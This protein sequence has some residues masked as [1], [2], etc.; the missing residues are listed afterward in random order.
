MNL[1]HFFPPSFF[2]LDLLFGALVMMIILVWI[3]GCG[4][5]NGMEIINIKE[6]KELWSF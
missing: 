3:Y 4:Q 5:Y 6:N 2:F 1:L